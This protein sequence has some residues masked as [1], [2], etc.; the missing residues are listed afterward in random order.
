MV[1]IVG[2][3]IILS[4]YFL[5]KSYVNRFAWCFAGIVCAL[6]ICLL[7]IL[8]SMMRTGNYFSY[9]NGISRMD[10]M[11]Y[12]FIESLRLPIPT[13]MR[14]FNV[15]MGIY[16][17]LFPCFIY[18]FFSNTV[19]YSKKVIAI[20]IGILTVAVSSV[21]FYDPDSMLNYYLIGITPGGK[22]EFLTYLIYSADIFFYIVF[23]AFMVIPICSL[24][25]KRMSMS[26]IKLKKSIGVIIC[27]CLLNIFVLIII[28][29]GMFRNVFCMTPVTAYL[30]H[31][32]DIS[33]N[34][35]LTMIISLVTAVLV[36][37]VV[38]NRL[39]VSRR[40]GFIEKRLCARNLHKVERDYIEI[41]HMFKNA[42]FSYD[43]LIKK[44]MLGAPEERDKNLHELDF[45][46]NDYIDKLNKVLNVNKSVDL[47]EKQVDVSAILNDALAAT[48]SNLDGIEVERS[49]KDGEV[50]VMAD[51][52]YLV[53]AVSNLIKN[54]AE[55]I[56]QTDRKG[57][58][59]IK[60]YSD[61]EW[62]VIEI[63]DNGTGFKTRNTRK[64]FKP[65]YTTK[66]RAN[67]WGIGLVH[68]SKIVKKHRGHLYA[69]NNKHKDGATMYIFLPR[70]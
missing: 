34:Q 55:A 67:N 4:V 10:Y 48:E 33:F 9:Y 2:S 62:V 12:G 61:F 60:A 21:F 45:K 47:F 58:I 27:S 63:V 31:V 66:S 69:V 7:L 18:F 64:I 41:F 43:I 15:M 39:D 5:I 17:V 54:A 16:M 37:F 8:V 3:L 35:Q 24:V 23:V 40:I 11:L 56:A 46:V 59:E 50:F 32:P 26:P 51:K 49:F 6:E 42:L 30:Y 57:K 53:E 44:A 36:M 22:N 25:K 28:L 14:I 38:V 19:R 1:I 65:L 68:T 20:S 52:F 70:W 13:I 29:S